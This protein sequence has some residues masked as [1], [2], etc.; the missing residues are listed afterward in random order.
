VINDQKFVDQQNLIDSNTGTISSQGQT[1]Y[2]HQILIQTNT[3]GIANNGNRIQENLN[4]IQTN[5]QTIQ[6]LSDNFFN[7]QNS[8]VKFHVESNAQGDIYW[9]SNTGI[10]F[11]CFFLLFIHKCNIT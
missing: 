6:S 4:G 11:K 10:N 2:D 5:G 7:S 8:L 3:D 9:P 1:L